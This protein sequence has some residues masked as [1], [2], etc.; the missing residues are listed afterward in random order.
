MSRAVSVMENPLA[1]AAMAADEFVEICSSA[2]TEHGYFAV[3]L[4]GGKTPM[5]MYKLLT[6]SPRREQIN[7]AQ[8]HLFFTD[9]RFVSPASPES[10]FGSLRDIWQ[11]AKIEEVHFHPLLTLLNSPEEAASR[12]EVELEQFF[13]T[14]KPR[15]DAVFLG[16][17]SD[18]HTA[19]LFPGHSSFNMNSRQSV[20][21]VYGA[22]KP[23]PIRLSLTLPVL[24]NAAKI[25]VMATGAEKSEIIKLIFSDAPTAQSLPIYLVKPLSGTMVWLIDKEAAQ[26]LDNSS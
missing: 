13:S 6:S 1:L 7:W 23:P 25:I 20:I 5:E 4:S 10:N 24:N 11:A 15:F 21:A 22:P 3:A 17:G 2:M 19:S 18:G 12:Y 9:E 16:V 26:F 14:K 8:V